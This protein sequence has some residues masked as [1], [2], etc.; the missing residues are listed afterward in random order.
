MMQMTNLLILSVN[1]T[2]IDPL[3]LFF[4]LFWLKFQPKGS[5][6]GIQLSCLFRSFRPGTVPSLSCP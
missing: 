6:L 3:V 1:R 2:S 4:F 5:I